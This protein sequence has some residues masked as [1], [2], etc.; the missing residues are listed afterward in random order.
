MKGYLQIEKIENHR[1]VS[2]GSI[3][4]ISLNLDDEMT[5]QDDAYILNEVGHKAW[6]VLQAPTELGIDNDTTE[7]NRKPSL[8]QEDS[9]ISPLG[10]ILT[11]LRTIANV[12]PRVST[13]SVPTTN[14]DKEKDI[15]IDKLT[16]SLANILNLQPRKDLPS[17]QVS[18]RI[19]LF[20][21]AN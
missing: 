15:Y 17:P 12:I 8:P 13:I 6:Y 16:P 5:G 1:L 2:L 9:I 7:E 14:N 21:H 18:F 10:I 4:D 3:G 11:P 20:E 19:R